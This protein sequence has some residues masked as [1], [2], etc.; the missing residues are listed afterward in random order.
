MTRVAAAAGRSYLSS[1]TAGPAIAARSLNTLRGSARLA[2]P[3][4]PAGR[5]GAASAARPDE[6]RPQRPGRFNELMAEVLA[7]QS[8]RWSSKMRISASAGEA[9]LV[10]K[11]AVPKRSSVPYWSREDVAGDMAA[12]SNHSHAACPSCKWSISSERIVSFGI[13][14]C[15]GCGERLFCASYCSHVALVPVGQQHAREIADGIRELPWPETAAALFEEERSRASRITTV[16]ELK[17]SVEEMEAMPRYIEI[18]N[19]SLRGVRGIVLKWGGSSVIAGIAI[20]GTYRL[21]EIDRSLLQAS[22]G[23][24]R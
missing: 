11:R 7:L 17:T 21:V 3:S 15:S 16:D 8:A 14:E 13:I 4:P 12:D 5:G 24:D 1:A 18:Q 20:D 2:R 19:G 22:E 9:L 10:P 23:T 6:V